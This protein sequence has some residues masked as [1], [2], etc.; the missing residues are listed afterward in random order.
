MSDEKRA[1]SLLVSVFGLDPEE[2]ED[3]ELVVDSVEFD[4]GTLWVYVKQDHSQAVREALDEAI[5]LIETNGVYSQHGGGASTG[6]LVARNIVRGVRD[7][8]VRGVK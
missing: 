7:H 5:H 1:F 8:H 6:A 3:T 2:V 4:E